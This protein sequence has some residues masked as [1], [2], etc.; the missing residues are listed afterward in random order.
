MTSRERISAII[1]HFKGVSQG[2]KG[3]QL[4]SMVKDWFLAP[5]WVSKRRIF[6]ITVSNIMTVHM[7]GGA[8][9]NVQSFSVT[10]TWVMH[11]GTTPL[12]DFRQMLLSNVYFFAPSY[13]ICQPFRVTTSQLNY[14]QT[15]YLSENEALFCFEFEASV[16]ISQRQREHVSF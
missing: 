16:R 8:S 4:I 14:F 13:T 11:S 5:S 6:T 3:L 1:T 2:A 15:I 10:S 7:L 9:L 12:I